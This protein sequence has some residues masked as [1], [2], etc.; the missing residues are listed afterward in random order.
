M[1]DPKEATERIDG[2]SHNLRVL[3]KTKAQGTK[4]LSEAISE[5][6]KLKADI[7]SPANFDG[8]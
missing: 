5:L 2:V 3:A 6:D 1:I 7:N 4:I 8:K